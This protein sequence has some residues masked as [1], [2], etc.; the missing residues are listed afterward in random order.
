MSQQNFNLIRKS[1]VAQPTT[2]FNKL[3]EE[4]RVTSSKKIDP[5]E[6][7]LRFNGKPCFP[8]GELDLVSGKAKSGK[9]MLLSMIMACC[10]CGEVL[11]LQRDHPTPGP[12]PHRGGENVEGDSSPER[13]GE[14]GGLRVLWYDTEQSEQSTQEIL[15][16]RIL[17]FAPGREELFDVFNVRCKK[18]EERKELFEKAVQKYSPDLVVLDGVRDLIADINDGPKA[19]ELV[20]SLMALAQDKRCCIVCVLH[21]NKSGEDRNPRGWIGTELL[22]KAFEVYSCEKTKPE[23]IFIVEQTLTRKYDWGKLMSFRIDDDTEMPVSCELPTRY[24]AMVGERSPLMTREYLTFDE[25]GKPIP[26]SEEL[27]Y[28][29]L[30]T[31]PMFYSD[32]QKKVMNKLNCETN[33]WNKIFREMRDSGYII[34]AKN[35]EGKSVW[36]LP[37]R[38]DQS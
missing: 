12:S 8:R 34:N 4:V 19:Q 14:N 1:V 37:A 23:N 6:Y 11:E 25:N 28:E 22:N 10:A 3:L 38:E 16:D 35:E 31:G 20:E 17:K 7:L 18:C 26:K 9:T 36:Q 33:M 29:A 32:L 21:Q 15:R 2:D 5:I 30:K 27:F 24:A 13:G